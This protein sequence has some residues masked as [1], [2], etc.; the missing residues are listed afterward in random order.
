MKRLL[1]LLS[2]LSLTS[3]AY[4][5]SDLIKKASPYSAKETMDKLETIVKSKGMT[6][7]A[8]I[9]H[10]ANAKT[11]DMNMSPAEVLIF[12]KPAA[13][14]RIMM[15]DATAGLDLPLRVLAYTDFDGKTWLVYHDPEAMKNLYKLSECVV[16][17][18]VKGAL[19]KMTNAAIAK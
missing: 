14:T 6:V 11:V 7:F 1:L 2:L 12:A 5:D 4:A 15:R 10:K 19:D 18:K 16:L 17:G 3:F 8:R 13:G 9:D